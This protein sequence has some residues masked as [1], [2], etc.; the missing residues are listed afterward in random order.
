MDTCMKMVM[1]CDC[2]RV[3]SGSL[4][5]RFTFGCFASR[6]GLICDKDRIPSSENEMIAYRHSSF[7]EIGGIESYSLD[8]EYI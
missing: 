3:W 4:D 7:G 2:L 5:I 6:R 8:T 1:K